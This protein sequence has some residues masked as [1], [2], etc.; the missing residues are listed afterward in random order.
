MTLTTIDGPDES[1]CQQFQAP[2]KA[3]LMTSCCRQVT[4][5][6][7]SHNDVDLPLYRGLLQFLQF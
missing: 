3:S 6:W 4:F 5:H 2:S 7:G 1:S